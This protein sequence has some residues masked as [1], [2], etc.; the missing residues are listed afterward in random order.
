MFL[1][2]GRGRGLPIL[3]LAL[4]ASAAPL[5]AQYFGRQKVQYDNFDWMT[6]KTPKFL[7]H[8]YTPEFDVTADG[9]RMAER[10]YTRLS[11]VFQHEFDEKP[12]IF[13]A[14]HPD[15]QQTNVISGALPEG[16]GG[17]T[18]G[19]RTRVIMPWTGIY[20]ENDHVLGHELVHVFQYDLA[21]SA[22]G[23]GLIGLS[24]LPD[25]L[26]EGMAEYLSLGRVDPHTAMWLRDA[27]IRGDLPT[28]QQLTTDPRYFPYRYGQALWAYIGG[29][30]GDRAVTEVLRIATNTGFE[31]ALVR[32]L[33]VNSNQLSQDWIGA[34]RA[35]YVPLLEG[36]QRPQDAGTRVLWEEGPGSLNISPSVSP[37]GR[38]VAFFGNRELFTT[39][40]VLADA[41]TGRII[42]TLSSPQ[43]DAHMDA[44]S[45]IQSSG[46]WSPDGEK[47]AYIIIK[48]GDNQIAILDVQS[49]DTEQRIPVPG[50]GAVTN[51]AWS[52]DG[53]SLAFSALRGGL[54]DLYM[55]NLSDGS[56]EQ[57]TNDKYAD[58]HPAWSPDGRFIAFAS[59]RGAGT[60]FERLTY[61]EMNLAM[62]DVDT[63]VV[64]V[65]DIFDGTKHID[66]HFAPDGQSLYFI[67]DREGIS[68]IYRIDLRT[69]QTWQ[70]TRLATGVSG[71]T[72]LAPAFSIATRTGRILFSAF[73]HAG[74]NVY[75]I[76]CAQA[77]GTPVAREPQTRVAAAAV[78]PPPEALGGGTIHAYL[79]DADTGLPPDTVHYPIS[80]YSA[81]ISLD[82]LGPPSFGVGASDY[83]TY[84]AGGVSAYFG[85]MLGDQL[86]ATAIQA[87]G[88]IKDIGGQAIYLNASDRI[89]WGASAGH[90]PYQIPYYPTYTV[91]QD[92]TVL[93]NQVLDRIYVDQASV[94]AQYPFSTTRRLEFDV[95]ATRYS[96][97]REIFQVLYNQFGQQLTQ[98]ERID[99]VGPDPI[100]FFEASAAW[101]G[102]NSYFAIWSPISGK[103][104]R[105]QVTPTFGSLDYTSVLAD[106]RT[107]ALKNP[108]TFAFR[109]LHYGRY[110][111]DASGVAE[112]GLRV[113]QPLFLGQESLVRGYDYSSIS[114]GAA[115]ECRPSTA[116]PNSCP[117]FDRLLGSRIAVASLELRI[118][119]LGVP[120]YGLLNFPFIPTQISPFIDAGLA[121]DHTSD[122]TFAFERN[123]PNRVPVFSA[124]ISAR[125]NLLGFA[126]LEGYYAYPF[127]RP[128]KGWHMGW[129]LFP[130]W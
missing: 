90:L 30:W 18:E 120:Q 89:T 109:A 75:S 28:I 104:F 106:Y 55:M 126:V 63:R 77:C 32:V 42:R 74:N 4:A 49:A 125:F 41:E 9:A 114:D 103:R 105:F 94:L 117:V 39:D 5:D 110:G 113:L 68:D 12:L 87:N 47:F 7:V 130:G 80:G 70:V 69:L 101:V 45:F 60:S 62:L 81:R 71:I 34:I 65:L 124:G 97:D 2:S 53:R 48:D 15:F 128:D 3:V 40:L 88:T 67:S 20:A 78:L 73:E 98:A 82:Y 64:R 107:Y 51:V 121:W 111:S 93:L 54:S 56:V 44:I 8:Y 31:E 46:S 27:A 86:I 13:Y 57:L 79:S 35:A 38:F 119:L 37:D 16:T 96:F 1:L 6:M 59:D 92:G 43:R 26:V 21:Q 66:P 115:V 91:N 33:G 84:L 25:W 99:T 10:W 17:V 129:Q 24:R 61:G 58:L 23:G 50:I 122:I 127:Q 76:D 123:S 36:R 19:L 118:P 83:G 85:D 11:R 108:I 14:D 22:T 72:A 100:H 29:R 116:N 102:D 112:D 52:P 95:G